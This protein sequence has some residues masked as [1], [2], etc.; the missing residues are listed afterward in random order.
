MKT[1]LRLKHNNQLLIGKFHHEYDD[2]VLGK[3]ITI[4][5]NGKP[6]NYLIADVDVLET[7]TD[8]TCAVSSAH[9]AYGCV[10]IVL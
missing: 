2:P 8:T 10:H 4:L 9:A 6:E 3:S 7:L 1:A 5:V